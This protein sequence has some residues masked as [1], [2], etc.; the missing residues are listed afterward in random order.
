MHY[1][2]YVA[3]SIIFLLLS[4]YLYTMCNQE[5]HCRSK[6][7]HCFHKFQNPQYPYGQL[8]NDMKLP[9]SYLEG[10]LKYNDL[11]PLRVAK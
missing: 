2:R 10:Q 4:K 7:M 6:N 8:L 11:V 5:V 1:L 3:I 9:G